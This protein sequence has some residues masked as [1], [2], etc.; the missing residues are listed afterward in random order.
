MNKKFLITLGL[1]AGL[2][3]GAPVTGFAA[4]K[5]PDAKPGEKAAA[6]EKPATEGRPI[7]FVGK[8]TAVDA[9]AKTFSLKGKEKDRVFAVTDKTTI[10]GKDGAPAKLEAITVG[11][12]VRGSATK[13][14]DAWTAGKV[15][16]GAKEKAPKAAATPAATPAAPTPAKAGSPAAAEKKPQ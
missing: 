3:L 6:P 4:E 2:A 16:I 1:L 11:E 9:A 10:V 5:K 13:N 14:G 12:E 7:P 15:T 8:V